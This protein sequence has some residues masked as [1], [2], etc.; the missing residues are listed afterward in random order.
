[1]LWH[2]CLGDNENTKETQPPGQFRCR[3][4][5]F[6]GKRPL[7]PLT[8]FLRCFLPRELVADNAAVQHS[9]GLGSGRPL[10][11]RNGSGHESCVSCPGLLISPPGTGACRLQGPRMWQQSCSKASQRGPF[12]ECW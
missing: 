2:V 9:Q 1:M 4:G 10:C 7:A 5:G 11:L 6:Y 8:D 12:G 3:R